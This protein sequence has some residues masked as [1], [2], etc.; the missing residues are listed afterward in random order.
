[1]LNQHPVM[2]S[3]GNLEKVMVVPWV[4]ALTHFI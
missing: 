1:M 2:E 3:S 4:E